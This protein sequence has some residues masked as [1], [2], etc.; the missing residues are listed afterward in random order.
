MLVY[1]RVAKLM[2]ITTITIAYDIHNYSFHGVYK[3]TYNWGGP[4]CMYI[5][6][7]SSLRIL[8]YIIYYH[9]VIICTIE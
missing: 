7:I 6:V 1:Q 9:N 4:H 3:P 2:Q 5:G 8:L